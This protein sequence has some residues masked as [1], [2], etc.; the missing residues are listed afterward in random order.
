METVEAKG[1]QRRRLS[2]ALSV[3]GA[4]GR[5]YRQASRIISRYKP[6]VVVGTGGYVCVPVAL[7]AVRRGIPLLLHEQNAYPGLANRMLSPAA[8]RIML[9]FPEAAGFFPKV[10]R[11]KTVWT[12]MP[13]RREFQTVNREAGLEAM[14]LDPGRKT[15]LATGG[16]QGA[17]SLN[18]AM[19]HVIKEWAENPQIQIVHVTGAR[20]Y[21]NV[22]RILR[23]GGISAEK[24]GNIKVTPYLDHMEYALACADLCV[25]R[26]S[27]G[28]L[29]E[30]ALSGVPGILIPF[31]YAAGDHQAHNAR[32]LE[33]AGAAVVLTDQALTG[34][35]LLAQIE[36]IFANEDRRRG[37]A[38]N[39][40]RTWKK[41]AEKSILRL[42]QFVGA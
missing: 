33:K 27:A 9:T 26:A 3:A 13:V 14:G 12:G 17:Q 41:D 35:K 1:W 28:F 24:T 23:Q 7:A 29:S 39:S 10:L 2:G 19:I 34:P 42:I 25:T 31:P 38:E 20:D 22:M 32:S 8:A 18:R 11:G 16:S 37:M 4:V 30:M 21:E 5:G 15:L 36:G 40:R 6:R